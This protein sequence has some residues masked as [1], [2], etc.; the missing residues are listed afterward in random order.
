MGHTTNRI[1]L[2]EKSLFDCLAS[3][4]EEDVEKTKKQ[5]KERKNDVHFHYCQV[6]INSMIPAYIFFPLPLIPVSRFS[7]GEKKTHTHRLS[8]FPFHARM[9]IPK[10]EK[11]TQ[12]F[13]FSFSDTLNANSNV[14]PAHIRFK[15]HTHTHAYML[16]HTHILHVDC[17]DAFSKGPPSTKNKQ[18]ASMII[19]HQILFYF[20]FLYLAFIIS[21][22]FGDG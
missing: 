5:K 13:P 3:M 10:R 20:S 7:C 22:H 6:A 9:I 16:I 1:P 14:F 12:I 4:N 18:E 8:I 15:K 19:I 11:K 21:F 2:D 17:L